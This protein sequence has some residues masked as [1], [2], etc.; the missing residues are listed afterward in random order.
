MAQR[1]G[2]DVH[3]GAQSRRF[4][5][6]DGHLD[7]EGAGGSVGTGGHFAHLAR[8]RLAIGPATHGHFLA[9]GHGSHLVLGHGKHHIT[10]AVLGDAHHRCTRRHHLAW[11]GI[12][13]G[14]HAS[15]IGHQPRV[16]GL[17]AL[18]G[19]LRLGLVQRG[20]RGLQ[21]GVAPLQLGTA[22]E[23]LVFQRCVALVVGRRQVALG[24][25]CCQL[26]AGSL[27][28]QLVVLGVQ[29]RQHIA[30]LHALAQFGLALHD[31]A[32]HAKAQAGLHPGAHLACIFQLRLQR[33]HA[34]GHQLDGTHG[35]LRRRRPRTSGHQRHCAQKREIPVKPVKWPRSGRCTHGKS[36]DEKW[37]DRAVQG[38][39]PLALRPGQSR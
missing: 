38:G 32:A 18:R 28:R 10:G 27:S 31:L 8:Q 39:L 21:G 29:L 11:L 35:L 7:L 3:G 1:L 14:H 5:A 25:G 33:P 19:Q 34:H 20:L 4:G 24:G 6:I 22:D 26:R 30:S 15:R 36:S 2:G 9:G 23:I 37:C 16:G 13:A 12:N 17:V